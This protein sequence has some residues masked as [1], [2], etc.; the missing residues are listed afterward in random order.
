M[1]RQALLIV[2]LLVLA[3]AANAQQQKVGAPPEASNMRLA[4]WSD[5]QG[6]APISPRSIARATAGSPISAIT[7]APT[8]FRPRSIR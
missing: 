3:G 5:L 1:T 8:T 6:A 7:A 4:G 2:G